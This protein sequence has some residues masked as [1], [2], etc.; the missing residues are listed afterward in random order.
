[1]RK[2]LFRSEAGVLHEWED[3]GKGGGIIHST[4]DVG[5][6]IDLNKAMANENDGYTPSREMRR[7][8]SIPLALVN[9]W[10]IEDGVNVFLPENADFLRRKLLDSDYRDLL[11][12]PV[13]GLAMINGGSGFR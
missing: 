9:K 8:G 6:I 10:L 7:I 3:D 1:M 5:E 4:A 13:K 12:A 11:T 2:P